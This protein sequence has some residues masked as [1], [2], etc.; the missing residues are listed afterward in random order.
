MPSTILTQVQL[1][2]PPKGKFLRK[3]RHAIYSSLT[4]VHPFLLH[5]LLPNPQNPVVFN[6]PGNPGSA[7]S[8]G[9][10]APHVIHASWIYL[11][12]HPKLHLD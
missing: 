4:P 2:R 11:T 12:Q 1:S 8:R 6:W 3:T 7:P 9:V 5:Y 10:S